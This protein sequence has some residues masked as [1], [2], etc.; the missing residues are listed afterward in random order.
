MDA[1]FNL[2][3][4]FDGGAAIALLDSGGTVLLGPA[5]SNLADASATALNPVLFQVHQDTPIAPG[6]LQILFGGVP[7]VGSG[8][9]IVRYAIPQ[10]L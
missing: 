8:F 1:E 10:V 5:D 2:L 7:T 9:L 6:N 4:P 3:N